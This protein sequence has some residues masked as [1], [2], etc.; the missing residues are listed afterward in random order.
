MRAV[1]SSAAWW[2]VKSREVEVEVVFLVV[3]QG[4]VVPRLK[5]VT[6]VVVAPPLRCHAPR[7]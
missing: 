4:I 1:L 5:E 6:V 3:M 7:M 2:A